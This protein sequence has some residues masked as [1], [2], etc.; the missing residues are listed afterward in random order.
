MPRPRSRNSNSPCLARMELEFV[1]WLCE[2]NAVASRIPRARIAEVSQTSS[3]PAAFGG[4]RRTRFR[5]VS[6][7]PSAVA[8]TSS[9]EDAAGWIALNSSRERPPVWESW[10]GAGVSEMGDNFQRRDDHGRGDRPVCCRR[11]HSTD[12]TYGNQWRSKSMNVNIFE[13]S[14][15]WFHHLRCLNNRCRV[16]SA[17]VTSSTVEGVLTVESRFFSL[18][19]IIEPSPLGA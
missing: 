19:L 9:V 14:S 8:C 1:W 16:E 7:R 12:I 15:V 2:R 4:T 6:W 10:L 5:S 17:Q 13:N 3:R 18:Q 11:L